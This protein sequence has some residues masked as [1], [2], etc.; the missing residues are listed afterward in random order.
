[1]FEV[2]SDIMKYIFITI[3]YYFM[4]SIIKLIS[5]DIRNGRMGTVND[6]E[7]FIKPLCVRSKNSF[8]VDELYGLKNG[9]RIGRGR[10]ADIIINDPFLSALHAEFTLDSDNNWQISDLSSTN[11]TFVNED[12]I[13]TEPCA[14]KTGDIIKMG[15]L[16]YIFVEPEEE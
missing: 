9:T 13:T 3:I 14:L 12:K 1:M 8:K 7:P 15:Q 10:K 5:K 4:F 6:N 11:G 2:L 16:S